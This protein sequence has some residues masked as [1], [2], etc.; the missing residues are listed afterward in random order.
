MHP[1]HDDD[2][3]LTEADRTSETR[4]GP[5]PVPPGHH[6]PKPSFQ[7]RRVIASGHVSPD[8]RSSYP[9]PS[10]GAKIAV[11]GGVA[12]G[13]AG[14]TAAAVLAVRKIA[15]AIS[16]DAH[17]KHP[18]RKFN[19][20][21]FVEMDEE[22]REAMRRRVRAQDQSDR[23]EAARL[24]AEAEQNRDMPKPAKVKKAPKGNFV[25]DLIHTSNRLSESLEGIAKSLAVAMD[26]FRSVARQATEVVSEFASTADQLRAAVR[27]EQPRHAH[28]NADEDR[29]HRL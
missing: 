9:T 3:P 8:G 12:V 10:L 13:V 20:P 21:R 16:G 22:E 28:R 14:G 19:A 26:G 7:A 18:Q 5:R 11:W 1:T 23:H 25:E 2:R 17:P 6:G 15:D 29:T 24:R 27:G 4:F